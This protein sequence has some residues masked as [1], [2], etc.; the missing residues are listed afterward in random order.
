MKACHRLRPKL[1][2]YIKLRRGG[3]INTRDIQGTNLKKIPS[4]K[5]RPNRKY[6][7]IF[8]TILYTD[9]LRLQ[10]TNSYSFETTFP[11]RMLRLP[12][13]WDQ[14]ARWHSHRRDQP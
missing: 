7:H 11:I 4:G 13:F 12:C 6:V 10:A 9:V 2:G 3:S 5:H 8:C 14:F 1:G